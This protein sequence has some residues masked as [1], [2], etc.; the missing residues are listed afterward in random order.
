MLSVS[1]TYNTLTSLAF[2][3]LCYLSLYLRSFDFPNLIYPSTSD[4]KTYITPPLGINLG[5]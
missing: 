3:L 4:Y 2:E 5:F 1:K